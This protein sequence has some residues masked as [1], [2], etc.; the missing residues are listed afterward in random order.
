[1]LCNIL[2]V[3]ES[4]NCSQSPHLAAH[5]AHAVVG[6][7][8]VGVQGDPRLISEGL[9]RLHEV[10]EPSGGPQSRRSLDDRQLTLTFVDRLTEQALFPLLM[11]ADVPEVVAHCAPV[12]APDELARFWPSLFAAPPSPRS[13]SLFLTF[14]EFGS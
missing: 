5:L 4:E 1:M 3:Q 13:V 10:V 11:L 9:D 12:F 2:A 7:L 8:L 14:G 6:Q